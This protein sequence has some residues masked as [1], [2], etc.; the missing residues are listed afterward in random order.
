MQNV[1]MPIVLCPY[2]Q[3]EADFFAAEFMPAFVKAQSGSHYWVC[4]PCEAFVKAHRK[5][6]EFNFTGVEPMGTLAD[7][8]LRALRSRVHDRFD[9]LWGRL[10]WGRDHAYRW[11]ATRMGISIDDCH[12]GMFDEE[13]C[14]KALKL[15]KGLHLLL[16]AKG[17]RDAK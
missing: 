13:A 10:G 17:K 7:R 5:N 14:R 9:I 3:K 2:C 11:L 8:K 16:N 1:T 12:V 4:V 15:L 6:A